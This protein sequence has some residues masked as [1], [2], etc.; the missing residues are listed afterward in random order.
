MCACMPVCY[1][2]GDESDCCKEEQK[3]GQVE[4]KEDNHKGNAKEDTNEKLETQTQTEQALQF[5]LVG[6]AGLQF[7]DLC[8]QVF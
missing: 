4:T 7:V 2:D 8:N 6:C 3:D 5:V 1:S